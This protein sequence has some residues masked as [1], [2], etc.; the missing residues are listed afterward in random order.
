MNMKVII[1]KECTQILK[2]HWCRS[3][4]RQLPTPHLLEDTIQL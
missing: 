4:A 3:F 1:T 2:S